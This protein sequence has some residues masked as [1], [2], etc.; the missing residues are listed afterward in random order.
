VAFE[1]NESVLIGKWSRFT[2]KLGGSFM[3][4]VAITINPFV[5]LL[6]FAWFGKPGFALGGV[7]GLLAGYRAGRPVLGAIAGALLGLVLWVA[8]WFAFFR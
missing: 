4:D 8:G 3:S 1:A 7:L 5:V 6:Y 2:K